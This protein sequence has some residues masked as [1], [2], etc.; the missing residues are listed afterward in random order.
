VSPERSIPC[1]AVRAGEAASALGVSPDFF[2]AEIAPHVPC[3]RRGH[4]K[5]YAVRALEQW[6]QDNA[7]Q[8]FEDRKA[9]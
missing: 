5:L 4:V 7:E 2:A 3:V 8:L 1:L 6:L 9:A